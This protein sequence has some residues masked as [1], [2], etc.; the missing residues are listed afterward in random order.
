MQ[1]SRRH[2]LF[3]SLAL[4][5]LAKRTPPERPNL[6]LFLIDNLP[7]WMLGCYGN[8]VV[9]T[10]NIDR[11]AETGV[12]FAKHFACAPA[13]APNRATFLT[14]RT[15]MQLGT[16]PAGADDT[17]KLLAGLGYTTHAAEAGAAAQFVE[18]QASG[19]PF[20]LT[21]GYAGLQP[22]YEG[23]ARKY[24]DL[25]ADAKLDSLNVDRAAAA[26]AR[27]GKEM[28]ADIAGNVRKVLAAITALDDQVGAIVAK[29]SEKRLLDNTLFI[30]T[31]TCGSLYGRHGLWDSGAASEPVN[32][33]EESVRTPML[34]SWIGHVPAQAVRP[35]LVSAYDFIPTLVEVLSASAPGSNLCGRSYFPLAA[36]KPLPRKR[37]WTTTVFGQYQNT[38]MA[39]I[40]R[41]KL[42]VR[43]GGQGPGELYDL[44]TDPGEKTNQYANPQFLTVH[45]GLAQS[46]STWKQRYS[47]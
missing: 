10:P 17:G 23:V 30:F 47:R 11:L 24:Q 40:E 45:N 31:G 1:V 27:E 42:I 38:E 34:W 9:H 14:G 7:A 37:P 6:L 44:V 21:V 25:Y 36:G 35:E 41:Y 28:L 8:Q 33:Y 12:R 18:S 4:P 15:P 3:S 39:R 26:N 29:I 2:I 19:K 5:A 46:L 20:F 13:P 43:D 16:N 32:M 22:P